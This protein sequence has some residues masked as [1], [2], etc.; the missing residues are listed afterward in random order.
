[1]KNYLEQLATLVSVKSLTGEEE[2]ILR[3]TTKF[4]KELGLDPIVTDA[5]I[6]ITVGNPHASPSLVMCSHLDT[7]PAGE[8][9][10]SPP[11]KGRIENDILVG[12]GAVDAKASCLA[13]IHTASSLKKL[14][15]DGCLTVALSIGEEGNN[16][17]LP[18]LL[19]SIKNIDAGIVGEPTAMNI[20]TS[21]RGLLIAEL[22]ASGEQNHA[23]RS[24][25]KNSIELIS[26][27]ILELQ[28]IKWQN[29]ET[30]GK[31]KVTPTRIEAGIAD[32]VTPPIAKALLDIRTTPAYSH[33]EI[34]DVLQKKLSSKVIEIAG[35]WIPCQTPAKAIILSNVKESL[36]D[37][38]CFSSETTSDWVFLQ[39]LEIPSVKVGPGN[40]K[41]SHKVNEQ[42][43]SEELEHGI[44]GYLNIAKRFFNI[45]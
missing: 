11:F 38:N 29:H 41:Y 28:S 2:K 19:D 12:R 44:T 23:A 21:Q 14:R 16:P 9:W 3:Y 22:Q 34:V 45:A 4:C 10:D 24:K 30:L 40:P 6:V 15:F 33:Q 5:G 39:Q 8:N 43:N 25:G 37:A 32:N 13:M 26:E 42:I 36:P 17:T 31:I 35:M 18:I 20:C 7:V 27:D 1:V